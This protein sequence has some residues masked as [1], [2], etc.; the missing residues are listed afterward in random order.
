MMNLSLDSSK[1]EMMSPTQSCLAIAEKIIF[2]LSDQ[3]I[4]KRYKD[5]RDKLFANRP[6]PST[7]SN[8]R[9]FSMQG[10]DSVNVNQAY[11]YYQSQAKQNQK[12]KSQIAELSQQRPN[13]DDDPENGEIANKLR[14]LSIQILPTHK[15]PPKGGA[16]QELDTLKITIDAKMDALNYM[17]DE[18]K[19]KNRELRNNYEALTRSLAAKKEDAKMKEE[20]ELREFEEQERSLNNDLNKAQR[21]LNVIIE[22]YRNANEENSILRQKHSDTTALLEGIQKDLSDTENLIE[23]F[24]SES[25]S[26][27]TQIEEQK[28]LLSVKTKELN[29]VQTVQSLGLEAGE[30]LDISDVIQSLRKKAEALRAENSQMAFELKRMDKKQSQSSI[31]MPTEGISMDEDELASHILKS[32]WQ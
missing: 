32:K 29:S 8:P 28:M 30:G 25:E 14:N 1:E 16:V 18:L 13:F 22:K 4:V 12:L 11:A 20:S 15:L 10:S 24:E 7:I 31:L 26:L 3:T 23:Q 5:F 21:D 6:S 9:S 27:F 17:R 19:T 2:S